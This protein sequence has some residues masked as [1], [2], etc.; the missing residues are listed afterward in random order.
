[1]KT[2]AHFT[3]N[4]QENLGSDAWFQLDGRNSLEQQVVDAKMR[5]Y[6]L[7]LLKPDYNGFQIRRGAKLST[8]TIIYTSK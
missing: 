7:R 5:M 2:Y 4:G 3:T 6:R 8:S 1:M